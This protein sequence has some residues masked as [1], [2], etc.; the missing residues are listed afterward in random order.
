MNAPI[1]LFFGS[2]TGNTEDVAQMLADGLGHQLVA[3]HD[4]AVDGVAPAVEYEQLIMGIPTWDFG[5]LQE[6]WLELWPE[7]EAMDL[8]GKQ[9]ALFGLGDQLGYG[10]W[11]LDAMGLLHDLLLSRGATLHGYTSVEGFS[12]EASKALTPDETQFVGLAI[13][14]DGQHGETDERVQRWVFQLRE[15]F[16]LAE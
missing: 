8:T 13:D 7:L 1:G 2:T 5:E 11:F 15:E 12:F 4:I 16:S 10:E 9:V 6:G 3:M 14:E